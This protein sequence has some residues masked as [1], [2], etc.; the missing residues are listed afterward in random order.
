MRILLIVDCYYPSSKS[1]AKLV[2]DLGVEMHRR[3]HKVTVLTPSDRNISDLELTTEDG[4]LVARIK[5]GQLKGASR[6]KRALHEIGLSKT[7]WDK[8][9]DF[10]RA[11]PQDLIVFYS[12]SIFFG[13]LVGKLKKLWACPAYLILRDIFPQW[14]VDAGVMRKGAAYHFFRWKEFVQYNAAD[15]I[16]V[17][18][19]ANL[20]YFD[21]SVQHCDRWM[22]ANINGATAPLRSQYRLE[23]LY[24]WTAPDEAPRPT[25]AHRERLGLQDK[26]VFFYGGNIGVAQDM[27][28]IIRLAARL[29]NE[30]RA[31]FLLVGEGS[32]VERLKA[33]I[34]A[35]GLTNIQML[36]A[37]GQK[38]YLEMLAEFDIGLM[39]LDRRLKT[40]NFPG[41]LLG[42]MSC[43]KPLLCSINP[44]NDL[45]PMVES[46]QAGLCSLNGDDELFTA[47]AMALAQDEVLRWRLG[48]NSRQLLEEYFS[49]ASVSAQILAHFTTAP[50]YEYEIE[51]QQELKVG[52]SLKAS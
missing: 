51:M 22:T 21:E 23:V 4:L 37:V 11:N 25:S 50:A 5:S 41:K 47:N 34:Q 43:A 9:K 36:P 48:R 33:M 24:N 10:F 39:S 38:E 12:P 35:Q 49:V 16:G 3:G 26:V 30:A 45:K 18:S 13:E 40:Q 17:Q 19:P 31:H 42:Y 1:S 15:V 6:I 7:L 8:G 28:N 20:A 14:A 2:H 27:D 52:A 32:E 46:H 29:K 44:G